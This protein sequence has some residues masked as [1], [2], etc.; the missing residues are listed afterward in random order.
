MIKTLKNNSLALTILILLVALLTACEQTPIPK[1]TAY[2]HIYFPAKAYKTFDS[3]CP[4]TF[5]YP[6]YARVVHDSTTGAEPCWLNVN[7][8]QFN[9]KL[10]LSYKSV[11]S[12]KSFHEFSEDAHTFAYKHSVKADDITPNYF[13]FSKDVTG[14]LYE[15]EGNTASSI[16]FYAT[17]S[18]E[19][20]L[21][22]ALYFNSRPNKDS[23]GPIIEYLRTDIDT[24]LKSLKWK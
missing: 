10:H 14:I 8:T 13:R 6:V 7:Y 20:Y 18:V 4:F 2:P 3:T 11:S 17:D 21:R 9:A 22:G 12:F 19:H 16:Q 24:F 1:P 5:R 23:L 15:I